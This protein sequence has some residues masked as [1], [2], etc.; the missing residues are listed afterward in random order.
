MSSTE[1]ESFFNRWNFGDC[2]HDTR[3]FNAGEYYEEKNGLDYMIGF[4][5]YMLQRLKKNNVDLASD[6]IINYVPLYDRTV[7]GNFP[8]TTTHTIYT[9][10]TVWPFLVSSVPCKLEYGSKNFPAI[11]EASNIIFFDKSVNLSPDANV[12][13]IAPHFENITSANLQFGSVASFEPERMSCNSYVISPCAGGSYL[14]TKFKPADDLDKTGNIEELSQSES[15]IPNPAV[16]ESNI[17]L[18]NYQNTTVSIRFLNLLGQ[19][20]LEPIV[21]A[22]GDE[23]EYNINFLTNNLTSGVYLVRIEGG[24][25]SKALRLKIEK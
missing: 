4:N 21:R 9:K 24:K 14:N 1:Y 11:I 20:V 2:L 15:L 16:D 18:T 5:L 13:F 25:T 6:N 7:V 23:S 10:Q 12:R 3:Q 17:R 8:R 22:I 19:D